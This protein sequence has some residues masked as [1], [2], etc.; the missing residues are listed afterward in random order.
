MPESIRGRRLD[1][2]LQGCERDKCD[3]PELEKQN[4]ENE[5]MRTRICRKGL[6]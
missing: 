5:V 1:S 6:L 4:S 2:G 3:P